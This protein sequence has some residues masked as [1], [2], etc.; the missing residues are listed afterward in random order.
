MKRILDPEFRYV[1][2]FDTDVRKTFERIRRER[3]QVLNPR[4]HCINS[5]LDP[6]GADDGIDTRRRVG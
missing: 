3:G 5:R 1:P 2:S 4:I 6:K